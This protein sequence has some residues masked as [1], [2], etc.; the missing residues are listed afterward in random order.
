MRHE[1]TGDVRERLEDYTTHLKRR[2]SWEI[3]IGGLSLLVGLALIRSIWDR[4]DPENRSMIVLFVLSFGGVMLAWG[5]GYY[6]MSDR[7]MTWITLPMRREWGQG[8]ETTW[9]ALIGYL[10]S[11]G[12][13]CR[14]LRSRD[15]SSVT[16]EL[17]GGLQVAMSVVPRE[18]DSSHGT[19]IFLTILR[20]NRQNAAMAERVQRELDEWPLLEEIAG[21]VDKGIYEE[22][23]G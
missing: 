17:D 21:G 9:D 19:D 5:L 4:L 6:Y 12:I 3:A 7:F 16:L 13:H 22:P 11:Q 8:L 15:K 18:D 10:T 14:R 23:T 2:G 1:W 20:I